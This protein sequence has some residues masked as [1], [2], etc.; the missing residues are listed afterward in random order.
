MHS[1]ATR[2]S[3]LLKDALKKVESK[4]GVPAEKMEEVKLLGFMPPIAKFDAS[5]SRL[6]SCRHLSVSS[7]DIERIDIP[8][9]LCLESLQL[10]RNR[11]EQVGGLDRVAKTL[12]ELTFSYNWIR[13]LA[14]IEKLT[15]LTR[16]SISNNL[17]N[18]FDDLRRLQ[19]LPGE[20]AHGQQPD[21]HGKGAWRQRGVVAVGS[22][23]GP[24]Q[25]LCPGWPGGDGR[26]DRHGRAV[27]L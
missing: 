27:M 24:A 16:L 26:R 25:P 21:I 23:K 11:I 3:T 13:S 14:G 17:I 18:D 1:G 10:G 15:R 22:P 8:H 9:M 2:G 7:N 12:S 4:L 5:L 20:P 19:Q 6:K